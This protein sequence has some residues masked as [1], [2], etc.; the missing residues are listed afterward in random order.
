VSRPE[1]WPA[2][3]G[4]V[5]G[6][7][8]GA[9]AGSS[10]HLGECALTRCAGRRPVVPVGMP[11]ATGARVGAREGANE[12]VRVGVREGRWVGVV[13]AVEPHVGGTDSMKY[14]W[15]RAR[16]AGVG[17]GDRERASKRACT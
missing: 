17:N 6:A 12:G 14:S 13:V 5:G 8:T 9:A 11:A 16:T 10:G 3:G 1:H 15:L 4:F 2:G 7:V